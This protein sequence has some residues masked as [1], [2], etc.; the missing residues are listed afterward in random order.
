MA[1]TIIS[2]GFDFDPDGLL[3]AKNLE[4]GGL[5]QQAID[6]SVIDW[7]LQYVPWET[8]TLGKSAYSVTKIGSGEVVYP[9]PYA[10]YQYYGEV[11]GPNIP[12]FEDDSG[13]PTRFFSPPGQKKSLTGKK[14]Q[15]STDVNPLAGSFWFERMKADHLQDIIQEAKNVAGVK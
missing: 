9:G 10:R 6:K 13:E 8:G 5:V 3:A 11:M 2:A 15:Y 12:V 14:L 4:E 7:D 1:K